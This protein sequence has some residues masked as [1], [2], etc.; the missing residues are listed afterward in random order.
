MLDPMRKILQD[1]NTAKNLQEVLTII[2]K[3]IKSELGTEVCSVFL[4]DRSSNRYVLMATDGLNPDAVGKVSLSASEGLVGLVA[5]REE[6]INLDDAPSHPRYHYVKTVKEDLYHAFLGVPIVHHRKV[7]GVL[8]VQQQK[9]RRFNENEETFL[10]TLS[11]QLAG[12]IAHAEATGVIRNFG[13]PGQSVNPTSFQGVPGASGV[14]IGT[15]VVI[16]PPADLKSVPDKLTDDIDSELVIIEAAFEAVRKDIRESRDKLVSYLPKE[17]Q[18]LFDVYLGMLDEKGLAGE[19]KASIKEGHWAQGALRQV[20]RQHVTKFEAME[21]S[22]IRERSADLKDLGSRI[23]S[24]LQDTSEVILE[25]PAQTILV[26]EDL[27]PAM[28]GEVPKDNLVGLVSVRGS[29]NSHVA[30]LARSMGITTVMGTVDMPYGQLDKREIIVDGYEG[31]VYTNPSIELLSTYRAL[32]A[33]E[34]QMIAE[35]E[36][37]KDL[38]CE[39]PDGQRMPLWVNTGLMV[40]VMRSIERGAEGVGLYRTEVPFMEKDRFPSEQEQF[41]TY[42]R[43]LE[44]FAPRSVTMRTLDIGGDKSLPYFPINEDNP[45]LGWRGIRVSLDHPEI[46]L[47]QLRA[48]LRASE[49]FDN[50]RIMLPMISNIL[51]VEESL[52]FV[53]Q[54]YY[55]VLEEGSK[56][57]MPPIGIMIETPAAVFQARD[58]A[59]WVDFVSVGS[60][61]LTQYL[62]AVDRNNPRVSDQYQTFHPAVLHALKHVVDA[63]HMEGKE[64]SICGEMAGEPPAAILLMAM[65]FDML[66][67]SAVN[68]PRIKW[69]LRNTTMQAAKEL[70]ADVLNMDNA[71]MI[72]SRIDLHLK[73]CGI[74]RR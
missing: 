61:D 51:E 62:L 26:S 33:D 64:V 66:S 19:V 17:E 16:F 5:L 24:Y 36:S 56:I 30:I 25:Y 32:V 50:L 57:K 13:T 7:L 1:I 46:F 74:G 22:Y 43:Q 52:Q 27:T 38:P 45:F 9:K 4:H 12:E 65:G 47:I 11:A 63:V 71:Q 44:I 2:V 55:E 49:G 23:L 28:L 59:R 53:N 40:D 31:R 8:V 39:T 20:I 37:L 35:L 73:R 34:Q 14:A 10:I 69:V 68:L 58:I 3:G 15:A 21:D 18:A 42:R 60:N 72:S 48:M 54:A 41:A 67:M 6:P 29:G 70:L